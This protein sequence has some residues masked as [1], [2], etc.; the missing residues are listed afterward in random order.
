MIVEF[1]LLI[2]ISQNSIS[3]C[4]L[5]LVHGLRISLSFSIMQA[6]DAA[7]SLGIPKVL[8]ASDMVL[9]AMP[10]KLTVMTYLYQLRSYFTGQT[11][12][13]QQIGSTA[14]ESTYML[15]EFDLERDACISKEMYGTG[16]Q[17]KNSVALPEIAKRKNIVEDDTLVS[18]TS[19]ERN[20]SPRE[21]NGS[22]LH[23]TSTPIK[24]PGGDLV[25]AVQVAGS[26]VISGAKLRQR[27]LV[28]NLGDAWDHGASDD[29]WVLQKN[30]EQ[31]GK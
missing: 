11:L 9:T 17:S 22:D 10:D 24:P 23:R 6:F 20:S 29:V 27:R 13:V 21:E 4:N 19:F 31:N 30:S 5:F 26:K 15:G 3:Y 18:N 1:K 14:Q 8:E 25:S 7:A 28:E 2:K 16:N 12:E